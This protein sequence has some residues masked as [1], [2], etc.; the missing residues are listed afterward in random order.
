[1]TRTEAIRLRAN[2][3]VNLWLRI[4]GRRAD[5]YHEIETV[6]HGIDISDDIVVTATGSDSIVV[7]MSLPHGFKGGVVAPEA[8]LAYLAASR[9]QAQAGVRRGAHIAITKGIPIG[10]GLGGGSADA[11]GALIALNELWGA[12]L[13]A[14]G[15]RVVAQD[16]G[17]DV[18][19]LLSGGTAIGTGRGEVVSTMESGGSLWLVL[20]ISAV[21]L[22]TAEVYGRWS[23][24]ER[25]S[26]A[27]VA[28]MVQAVGAGDTGRIAGLLHNDLE[29]PACEL[30]PGLVDA[31]SAMLEAGALG[32]R[33]SGSGPTIFGVAQDHAHAESIAGA[34]AGRFDAVRTACSAPRS[35]VIVERRP[36]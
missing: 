24:A 7:E 6:F 3:K 13:D 35:I 36:H 16:I 26:P 4:L 31:V 1:M 9:L 20:G 22:S 34:L 19:F 12:G 25:I 30:R 29:R 28:A 17:S 32:A 27:D 21:P 10:A 15:L 11:A 33:V 14:R 5:G 23:H 2:G 18:P 8:N